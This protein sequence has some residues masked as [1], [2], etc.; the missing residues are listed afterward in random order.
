LDASTEAAAAGDVVLI[1]AGNYPVTPGRTSCD[2]SGRFDVAL[3]SANNGTSGNPITYRGVGS[4]TI[5]LASGQYGPTIGADAR[6]Y[7]VWD[8][9]RIDESTAAG[10]ACSDTGPVVFHSSTGSKLLNS[11]IKGKYQ[12]WLDNYSGV[13]LE[14]T[15]SIQIANNTIYNFT[16]AWGHNDAG[17]ISYDAIDTVIEHN[18]VYG[19]TTGLY[20]K[21][22]HLDTPPNQ[23]NTIVRFNWIENNSN[24]AIFTIAGETTKIYQNVI[25]APDNLAY[26]HDGANITGIQFVNNT[27]INTGTS[28]TGGYSVSS[29]APTVTNFR[30]YNNIFVGFGECI[31]LGDAASIGGQVFEHNVYYTCTNF[32]SLNGSLISLTTWKTTYS[33]DNATPAS[34]NADPLFVDTVLY[35]LQPGSPARTLGID[36]LDL[37][38]DGSTS[39][40]I[41]AG[42]Y[43]TGIEVIGIDSNTLAAPT[44][45]VIITQ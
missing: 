36:V 5:S 29:V 30:I 42:A 27:I 40:V 45:L 34:I 28:S 39:D 18:H 32:G 31:A 35:K 15:W 44:G 43:V 10:S 7:I 2:S 38:R 1:T 26:S 9:V 33:K 23:E 3:N 11:N 21:G 17:F 12:D 4:V 13:R 25:E 22:D 14:S 20:I 24:K 6:N 19:N 16:G 37:D 41:P 8:T